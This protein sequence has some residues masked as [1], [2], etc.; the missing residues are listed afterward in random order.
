MPGKSRKV[1]ALRKA[2]HPAGAREMEELWLHSV[3]KEMNGGRL[4]GSWLSCEVLENTESFPQNV[5]D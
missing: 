2:Q 3:G 5:S 4:T 1:A